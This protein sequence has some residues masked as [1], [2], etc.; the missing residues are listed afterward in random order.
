MACGLVST[1]LLAQDSGETED[2]AA[3]SDGRKMSRE[4]QVA[5]VEAQ[6]RMTTEPD[7]YASAREPL[8][9]YLVTPQEE[10]IPETVYMMLG[11]LYYVDKSDEKNVEE[12]NKIYKTAYAA[13][14]ENES[15][16]LNYAVTT[17]EIDHLSEAAAL[18]EK[19]YDV[20]EEKD[21]QFLENAAG[22]YF[23]VE[24]LKN[25]KRIFLRMIDLVEVPESGWLQNIIGICQLQENVEETEKYIWLS[26]KYYPME[27]KF[28]DYLYYVYSAKED[29][30]GATAAMEIASRI[31]T[32][33]T[34][35][36]WQNLITLY[37][38]LGLYNRS[39]DTLKAG[40]DLI[41]E[42]TGEREETH[43]SIADFYARA[44]KVDNAIAYLDSAIAKNPSYNLKIKKAEIL[45]DA[46]RNEEA[47]AA[48]DDCIAENSRAY[49]AYYMKG[50]IA[51]D[52][53]DW[54]TAEEAF[55]VSSSSKDD[56]IRVN[57]KNC[58]DM[59][60]DLEVARTK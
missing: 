28:W 36:A 41:V 24:D 16:L 22:L 56:I 47:L 32:P 31:V 25:A 21:M 8:V 57:S 35:D 17:Y 44:G 26:L 5:L 37:N 46:R 14:P 49:D 33:S 55:D 2:G 38:Y 11:Q 30:K 15:F 10:P 59:L 39:A 27:K 29:L 9:Q 51:W 18:F 45:Y 54:R 12:A 6:R 40:F 3:T 13:F 19:Y 7:N 53:K 4:A 42:K 50:W 1:S 34:G 43:L 60:A 52:M 48:L 20:S 23:S 58:L